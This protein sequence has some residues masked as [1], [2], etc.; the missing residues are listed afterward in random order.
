MKAIVL[1]FGLD[2][3]YGQ[4]IAHVEASLQDPHLTLS[5]KIAEQVEDGSLEKFGQQ[6][7]TSL[8]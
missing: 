5:G 7:R 8:P 4:L 1:H 6:R 2:D 3:Y